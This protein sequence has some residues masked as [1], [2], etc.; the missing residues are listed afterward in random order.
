MRQYAVTKRFVDK[1]TKEMFV[2][3]SV[4]QLTPERAEELD[5][6]VELIKKADTKKRGSKEDK[7]ESEQDCEDE[8]NDR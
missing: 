1:Y 7:T 8:E 6:Y 2:E 5:G 3:G 4:V